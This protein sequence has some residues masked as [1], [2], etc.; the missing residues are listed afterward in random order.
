MYLYNQGLNYCT[1]LGRQ[2]SVKTSQT[3]N[4]TNQVYCSNRLWCNQL[5]QSHLLSLLDK[6]YLYTGLQQHISCYIT[7][8]G[9]RMCFN[10]FNPFITGQTCMVHVCSRSRLGPYHFGCLGLKV[11]MTFHLYIAVLIYCM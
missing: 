6:L 10:R 11:L 9:L 5:D 8:T 4:L 7:C 3:L 2:K 1:R